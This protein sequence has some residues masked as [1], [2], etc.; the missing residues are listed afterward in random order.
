M[1]CEE[2]FVTYV[3]TKELQQFERLY[4]EKLQRG[5]MDQDVQ[6]EYGRCLVLSRFPADIIKGIVL[7]EQLLQLDYR[8]TECCYLTAIGHTKMGN[9]TTAVQ[10]TKIMLA[11]D[12]KNSK[13]KHLHDIVQQKALREY[14]FQILV[15]GGVVVMMTV[16]VTMALARR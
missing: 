2:M 6:Y 10:F 15:V 12:P 8:A 9:Y 16:L 13:G 5:H 7:M 3:D 14:M 11:R 4:H 1:D